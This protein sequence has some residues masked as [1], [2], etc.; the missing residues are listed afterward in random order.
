VAQLKNQQTKKS[1]RTQQVSEDFP[2]IRAFKSSLASMGIGGG[3]DSTD[4]SSQEHYLIN[5]FIK[6]FNREFKAAKAGEEI[7]ASKEDQAP[8]AKTAGASAFDDMANQ[9]T[10]KADAKPGNQA[11][12]NMADQLSKGS[13]QQDADGDGKP[14]DT[15][16]QAQQSAQSQKPSGVFADPSEFQKQWEAYKEAGGSFTPALKQA[17]NNIWMRSGGLTTDADQVRAKQKP[18]ASIQSQAG[19]DVGQAAAQRNAQRAAQQQAAE[20]PYKRKTFNFNEGKKQVVEYD[21][22]KNIERVFY[23]KLPDGQKVYAR[24]ASKDQIDRL[25]QKYA[26]A[27]IKMFDF[28]RPEV[29]EWLESRRINLRKFI[30]GTVQVMGG[31]AESKKKKKL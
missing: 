6:N 2:T 29:Q 30:P 21:K 24:V 27:D 31:L 12:G 17:L 14:D 11:F 23:A 3:K 1:N 15:T 13:G 28:N 8:V 7:D 25:N 9:L 16:A 5:T 18:D 22:S 10:A 19:Q 20:Q 4:Y 26:D